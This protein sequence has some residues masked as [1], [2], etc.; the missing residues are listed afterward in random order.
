MSSGRL[1]WQQRVAAATRSVPLVRSLDG[2]FVVYVLPEKGEVNAL[3]AA[4]G[5][6]AAR[7][8]MGSGLSRPY[9]TANGQYFLVPERSTRQ[10]HV[11]SQRNLSRVASFTHDSAAPLVTAGLFD[12]LAVAY[13]GDTLYAMD[14]RGF[15]PGATQTLALPGQAT[16]AIVTSDA[17]HAYA[18][19]PEHNSIVHLNLRS[20]D[21]DYIEGIASPAIVTMGASNAVCH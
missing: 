5:M 4:T 9:V 12:L 6:P 2:L 11:L 3:L 19:I 17:R 1:L 13:G 18:A 21:L 15:D 20:G 7:Q 16:D 8:Q 14:L 10:V